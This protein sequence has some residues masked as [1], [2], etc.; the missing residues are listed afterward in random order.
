M[1]MGMGSPL[2]VPGLNFQSR[3]LFNVSLSDFSLPGEDPKT[4]AYCVLPF[5]S[6]TN[7][8]VAHETFSGSTL[9]RIL[10]GL[11][12]GR[13]ATAPTGQSPSSIAFDGGVKSVGSKDEAREKSMI[14]ISSL[15]CRSWEQVISRGTQKPPIL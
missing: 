5:V 1:G 10:N 4:L 6:T 8:T 9:I 14:W 3:I 15:R 2:Q 11:D 12:V 13:G 7:Q